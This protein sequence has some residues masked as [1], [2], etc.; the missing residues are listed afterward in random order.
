[1]GVATQVLFP[2]VLASLVVH[3]LDATRQEESQF[4]FAAVVAVDGTVAG[5]PVSGSVPTRPDVGRN[6]ERT[7]KTFFPVHA[8][9]RDR[10]SH[11][12]TVQTHADV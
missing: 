1:M 8:R 10:G 6:W 7:R 3:E 5:R 11:T 9:Y 2:T 4:F 12:P